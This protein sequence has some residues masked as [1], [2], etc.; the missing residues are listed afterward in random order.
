MGI[1]WVIWMTMDPI[2]WGNYSPSLPIFLVIK[3]I[4]TGVMKSRCTASKMLLQDYLMNHM[5]LSSIIDGPFFNLVLVT[6]FHQF[7]VETLLLKTDF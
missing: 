2:K 1:E 4:K 3:Q 5:N 7:L 6:L